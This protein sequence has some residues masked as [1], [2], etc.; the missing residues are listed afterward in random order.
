MSG[1]RQATKF[2]PA[3]APTAPTPEPSLSTTVLATSTTGPEV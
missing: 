2:T 1:R 3:W